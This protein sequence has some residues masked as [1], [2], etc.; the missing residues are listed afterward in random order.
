MKKIIELIGKYKELILYIVFGGLTTAVNFVAFWICGRFLG[1]DL[2][3]VSN[4]IAWFISVVFAYI[5]NKLFVFEA[6]DFSLKVLIKEILA[7]FGA[8]I[9]SFGVE[10]GGLWLM[11]DLLKFGEFSIN[12]FG[13][14]IGGQLIA[15]LVLAVVVVILNYFA[16][17]FVIFKKKNK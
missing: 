12:V 5:T 7:F 10:E 15:K 3:L 9:F 4:A 6:K 1:E 17:K 16:S 11:I 2:Y 14:E 13:F 8:R